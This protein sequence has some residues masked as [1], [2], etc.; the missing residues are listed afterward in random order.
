VGCATLLRL[1]CHFW[2][3]KCRWYPEVPLALAVFIV[4]E[5]GKDGVRSLLR[6]NRYGYGVDEFSAQIMG[7]CI[8]P[9]KSTKAESC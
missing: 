8:L 9:V 6:P 1:H 4:E 3:Q 7:R 2:R 5:F